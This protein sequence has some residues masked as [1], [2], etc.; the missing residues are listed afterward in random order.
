MKGNQRHKGTSKIGDAFKEYLETFR[1]KDKYNQA[2]IMEEWERI[3]GKPIA[4]RTRSIKLYRGKMKVYV[5]SAPLKQE[6]NMS[7]SKVLEILQKE[8]G[9]DLI[10]EVVFL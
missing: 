1:I 3:M 6:L 10:Q 9:E 7:R 8:Y 2:R 4:N 5:T